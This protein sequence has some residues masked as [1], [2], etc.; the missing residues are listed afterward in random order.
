MIF[1]MLFL[2]W[3]MAIW[4]TIDS[5]LTAEQWK[6]TVQLG[7]SQPEERV[8]QQASADN[9]QHSVQIWQGLNQRLI[10]EDFRI[11]TETWT[12]L[13]QSKTVSKEL[14]ENLGSVIRRTL[15]RMCS[16][17]GMC[18]ENT[19]TIM[20]VQREC[21]SNQCCMKFK[22]CWP[23]P[24]SQYLVHFQE[25]V[26]SRNLFQGAYRKSRN[27]WIKAGDDFCCKINELALIWRDLDHRIL[28]KD[29]V[30]NTEFRDKVDQK[31]EGLAQKSSHYFMH[32][33]GFVGEM[34]RLSE[35]HM[36]SLDLRNT[37]Y[38]LG[39]FLLAPLTYLI[40]IFSLVRP[41][42]VERQEPAGL[43]ISGVV[44]NSQ[45]PDFSDFE[46]MKLEKY[47]D[48]DAIK[49]LRSMAGWNCLVIE[50]DA[51]GRQF[52]Q[53][54]L[55]GFE[56]QCSAIDSN[57]DLSMERLESYD[58]IVS[59]VSLGPDKLNGIDFTRTMREKGCTVP[60]LLVS[61]HFPAEAMKWEQSDSVTLGIR[62]PLEYSLLVAGLAKLFELHG[63]NGPL[64]FS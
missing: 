30:F 32:L 23:S 57:I 44:R 45:R 27:H 21:I 39:L 40:I 59:D 33:N 52:L 18:M 7:F 12:A 10:E 9:G 16:Q 8:N 17:I 25:E 53:E 42:S 41:V 2:A 22:L 31:L 50:D 64:E 38:L 13:D 29:R 5:F 48:G 43:S 15:F 26:Q 46:G 4:F 34:E 6:Q 36:K 24:L 11:I 14:V 35:S 58:L 51:E 49:I 1:L 47:P 61:A 28:S 54:M 19:T 37:G 62:K 55:E 63:D 20:Q 3:G 60:V 56:L